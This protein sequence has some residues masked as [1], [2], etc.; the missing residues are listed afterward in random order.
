VPDYDFGRHVGIAHSYWDFFD[1][2]QQGYWFRAFPSYPPLVYLVGAAATALG[3]PSPDA[4]TL[5]Q[6]VVF[7]P[8]LVGG[9]YLAGRVAYNHMT[10]VLAAVFALG[11]PILL[12]QFHE[13]MLDAP[14][15]AVTALAV[16][17]ILA[18]RRFA[19][20]RWS[21]AAGVAAG[22]GLMTKSPVFFFLV[23]PVAVSLLRGGW[24]HW[25][26]LLAFVAPALLLAGPWYL[27]HYEQLRG[28]TSGAA[29]EVT[30]ATATSITPS[31]WSSDN[32]GWYAWSALNIG[33]L[34]PLL[35]LSVAG[36]IA[37]VVRF[38]RRRDRDD[39]TLELLAGLAG[40][41]AG[42]TF[43]SLKDPRYALPALVYLA[44]LGTGWITRLPRWPRRALAAAVVAIAAVNLAGVSMGL[45]EPVRIQVLPRPMD[46]NIWA[47]YVTLYSPQ[48]Y[49]QGG[50]H[51]DDRIVELF[52][53]ARRQGVRT[54]GIEPGGPLPFNA[55]GLM[56][57]TRGMGLRPTSD[58]SLVKPTDAIV[59]TRPPGEAAILLDPHR[60]RGTP[61][62]CL[63]VDGVGV[64]FIRGRPAPDGR[65][66]VYCPA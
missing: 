19:D 44:V 7:V 45:G 5:A 43:V 33:V 6:N 10:G 30:A 18:S 41:W 40:G 42:I 21:L 39:L 61:R 38:V 56:A 23:G 25:R 49:L 22:L 36:T 48:G 55:S 29:G 11:T 12:D 16:G 14:S 35:L 64:Y 65:N 46:G 47:R 57:L 37:S 66:T 32:L 50:P 2:G 4:L 52:E 20:W 26:G 31:R 15:A 63:I 34:L 17:L 8:M 62:P 1:Y 28:L 9:C 3:E 59:L 60:R 24:R 27:E 53:A 58:Y 51:H 13:F 54:I